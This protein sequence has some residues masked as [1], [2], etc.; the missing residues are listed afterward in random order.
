VVLTAIV[1]GI[2]TWTDRQTTDNQIVPRI[3][4]RLLRCCYELSNLI[5]F[6]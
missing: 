1:C 3:V 5:N 6:A 4:L 2:T